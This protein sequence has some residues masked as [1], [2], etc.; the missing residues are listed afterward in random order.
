ME[1][2]RKLTV[3]AAAA[4]AL[5]MLPAQ[6][7]QAAQTAQPKYLN[8]KLPIPVR[9]A[10][11]LARMTLAE[12]IGQMTQAERGAVADDPTRVATWNLGS[13]LSGGGSVP[14]PNTP[15]AWATMVN[16]F[17]AQALAT[18]LHIP[19][20][21]GVDAV[22]GHGN[23]YGATIFPHNIGLGS[24]RDPGL[25]R[26]VGAVTADE[27]RATGIPWDFAPCICVS[28][29]ER[30]GR[31]YESFGEDPAL[32]VQM[33][34][35]I[36]GLQGTRP[37][38]LADGDHVLA[39]AKHFAGDGDTDYDYAKA[40]ANVGKN[41]WE[42]AYTIDQGVTI[43]SRS[44]FDRIDLPQYKVAVQKR[45]VG[46]VMPSF[47]SVDFTEDGVGN[48][49]KMHANGDLINGTLKH[50]FGFDGFVISDWEGIHQ[51]PDPSDPGNGGLTAYKVATA[52]NAGIDMAM[53]PNSAPQFEEL[54]L[55]E[56]NAGHVS[57]ARIDDAVSRILAAKF[58]LGLFEH[59]Y[60]AT[61]RGDEV[62][63]AAHRA[64]AR[65]AAAESQVLLKNDHVL[66]LSPKAKIYVAG[67][68]AD[69]LG[70]QAGG[71][72]ISWQGES[73]AA[74]PGT[75]ILAG[76]RE[77]APDAQITYSADASAPTAGNDVGVVVVGES[78]YAE[79]YGDIGGPECGWCS[80]SQQVSKSLELSTVDK[81]AIDK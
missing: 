65:K 66:P 28:R 40:A 1:I 16:T 10:D 32:A 77:D 35:I 21:Y 19:M 80:P 75:S 5:A 26:Q 81:A 18:R 12:K 42:K 53:E 52:V 24:T 6:A 46:S 37:A 49:V 64:V 20:I 48:P 34:S 60:A 38:Q 67:S 45:A 22:H 23:V 61:D 73:G 44:D 14:T 47:S 69:D 39:T 30:W 3:V 76:L 50:D 17:Q 62:G 4:L 29:D 57:V 33:T 63:S 78:A 7:T 71:W 54:L 70:H 74:I 41:W 72:T 56:V 8:A 51:I 25:V 59:P 55:G 43:T 68:N 27:V 15:E 2:R 31:S 58:K 36:D 79:G 11:L 9:V 13:V